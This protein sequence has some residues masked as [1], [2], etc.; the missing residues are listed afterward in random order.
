ME[1]R[2]SI[3]HDDRDNALDDVTRNVARL[4]P[5]P[6]ELEVD[7][8]Y[9]GALYIDL[10]RRGGNDDPPDTAS[11]D[12]EVQPVVWALDVEGGRETLL[13]NFGPTSNP[14]D[15]AR[16]ITAEA[17][18]LGSPASNAKAPPPCRPELIDGP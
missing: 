16:W 14:V 7:M 4:L 3:D 15:V 8:S 18:R 6:V 5:F 13:S 1:G 9:T 17:R 2:L 12:G 10:G 11:I